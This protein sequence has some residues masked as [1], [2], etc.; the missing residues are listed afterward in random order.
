ML[1][2]HILMNIVIMNFYNYFVIKRCLNNTLYRKFSLNCEQHSKTKKEL[3]V[4]LS[5]STKNLF[6]CF[7]DSP[8]KMTNFFYFILK[9]PFVLKIF[10]FLSWLFVHMKNG[11]IIKIKLN[12]KFLMSQ[13]KNKQI[14]YTYCSISHELK[15]IRQWNL[16]NS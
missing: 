1:S 7:N 13:I 16:A 5:S 10:N 9:A 14:Q 12:S 11:L 3:K 6:I 2:H 15:S 8:S 4:G